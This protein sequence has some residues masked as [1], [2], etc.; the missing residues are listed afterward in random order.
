MQNPMRDRLFRTIVLFIVGLL[1]VW[2]VSVFAVP[3]W[4]GFCA[5]THI[6]P[7]CPPVKYLTGFGYATVV[8]GMLTIILGP[9]VAALTHVGLHGND[10][11]TPRGTETV[12]TNSP[13]LIGAIY[14]GIGLTALVLA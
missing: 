13:L 5:D 10:W 8:L 9:V 14:I 3:R 2:M 12:H 1:V 4:P 7:E 6:G 11:E